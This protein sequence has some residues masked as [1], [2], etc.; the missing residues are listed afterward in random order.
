MGNTH[1]KVSP[2]TGVGWHKETQKW[3]S[4]VTEKNIRY[5]CGYHDTDREAAKA[6]DLK[7]LALGLKKPLQILKPAA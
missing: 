5:E 3:R 1:N 4:S 7:I 6:R 2:Y